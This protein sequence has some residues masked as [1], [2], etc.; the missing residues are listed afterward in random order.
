MIPSY[1]RCSLQPCLHSFCAACYSEWMERKTDCP[2]VCIIYIY[3]YIYIIDIEEDRPLTSA[4]T[5]LESTL[6]FFFK[7]SN[8]SQAGLFATSCVVYNSSAE[9]KWRG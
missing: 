9:W 5:A 2:S 1:A 3:I 7:W 6:Q 4:N 8:V